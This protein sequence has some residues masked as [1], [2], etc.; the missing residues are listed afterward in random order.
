MSTLWLILQNHILSLDLALE[1][2]GDF[3]GPLRNQ[4]RNQDQTPFQRVCAIALTYM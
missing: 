3:P 4:P 2:L 1:E